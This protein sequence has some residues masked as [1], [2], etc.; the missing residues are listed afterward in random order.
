MLVLLGVLALLM[1]DGPEPLTT[2]AGDELDPPPPLQAANPANA[3][4][5]SSC[6]RM[7]GPRGENT[8]EEFIL[9]PLP[10]GEATLCYL[11][12]LAEPTSCSAAA[13]ILKSALLLTVN[14]ALNPNAPEMHGSNEFLD[15]LI[16]TSMA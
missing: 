11:S 10:V 2:G 15:Y 1:L 9:G 13:Q 14:F 8:I 5:V 7:I 4:T 16:G 12:W 6:R 3:I